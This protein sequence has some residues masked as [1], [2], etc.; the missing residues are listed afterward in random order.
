MAADGGAG[1]VAQRVRDRL[2]AQVFDMGA[3]GADSL[4][5]AGRLRLD[6]APPQLGTPV[7]APDSL[8]RGTVALAFPL[9]DAG[10]IGLVR[11]T[12]DGVALAA[13]L[14]PEGVVQ[15][16]WPTAGLPAGPHALELMVSD[17][18][19]NVATYRSTLRV[20]NEAPRVRL[21]GPQVTR[22]GT[23]VRIQASVLDPGSGLAERP[24]ITFGDGKAASGFRLAHRYTR[25]GRYTVTIRATDRA[26][27]TAQVRRALRVRAVPG[28]LAP[29]RDASR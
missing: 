3:P 20:D 2:V 22:A 7:P 19:G 15:A 21:R 14:T 25:A 6:L 24:R 27:N 26:G 12:I 8:V 11:L 17:Q 28:K 18:T 10:S 4:F 23:K 13:A 5:G 9:A 29:A 1:S 16:S